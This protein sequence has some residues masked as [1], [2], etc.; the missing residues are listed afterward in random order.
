MNTMDR[1]RIGTRPQWRK[2]TY[3]SDTA[4]C[5]EFAL[6]PTSEIGVRDSKDPQGAVLAY[7]PS[8]WRTFVAAVQAG[9]LDNGPV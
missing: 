3:S 6:L 7:T 5:V 9:A 1:A 8:A 2:S 4:N